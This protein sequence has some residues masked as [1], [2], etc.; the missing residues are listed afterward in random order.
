MEAGLIVGQ[1]TEYSTTMAATGE[2]RVSG[3]EG[4]CENGD[5]RGSQQV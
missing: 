4:V 5:S 2:V 3:G 1:C